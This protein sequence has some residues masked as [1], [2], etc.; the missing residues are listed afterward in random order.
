MFRYRLFRGQTVPPFEWRYV[1]HF[2]YP[3]DEAAMASAALLFEGEHDFASFAAPSGDEDEL[4]PAGGGGKTAR[5]TLRSILLS[6]L[7]RAPQSEELIY[8]VRGRSFLRYMVRKIVGTLLEIGRGRMTPEDIPRLF[9]L[10]DQTRSG[11]TVPA[12]GLVLVAVEYP[13]PWKIS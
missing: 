3:L 5:S 9:A 4:V 13:D 10:R 12:R 7:H 6:G 11:P 8:E 1:Y 2:Q